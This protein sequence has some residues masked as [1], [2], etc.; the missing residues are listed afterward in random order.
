MAPF[1]CVIPPLVPPFLQRD[2]GLH[3]VN[4]FDTGQAA[5]VLSLPS[6]GL[7]FLLEQYCG[8][9][10]SW[11]SSGSYPTHSHRGI[12]SVLPP[13][14]P[15]TC[16]CHQ[17]DKRYQLADWRV[18]P[19]SPQH[20]HY[21]RTDTHYLLYIYDRLKLELKEAGDLV[22]NK[23]MRRTLRTMTK[24]RFSLHCLLETFGM[25]YSFPRVALQ[26]TSLPGGG[27]SSCKGRQWGSG[28]CP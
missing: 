13:T 18:R 21:A 1:P 3:L 17:A 10:V 4:L 14:P 23:N 7:A 9:K 5:R 12:A 25:E 19:L 11:A 15:N 6:A 22:G 2:F 26:G 8:V 20:L 28:L 27:A 16:C 24:V